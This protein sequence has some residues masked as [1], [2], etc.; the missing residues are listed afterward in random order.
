VKPAA[1]TT[2]KPAPTAKAK[3]LGDIKESAYAN[4][5]GAL[6][7]PK[8]EG[9]EVMTNA[10]GFPVSAE[11]AAAAKNKKATAKASTPVAKSFSEI[12][13]GAFANLAGE[14]PE[15]K[16]EAPEPK[17]NQWGFPVPTE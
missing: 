4:L 12:R 5:R 17:K 6:P 15:E 3:T 1:A 16:T 14:L 13:A 10:Y 2:A 8:A 11:A 9:P 7:A